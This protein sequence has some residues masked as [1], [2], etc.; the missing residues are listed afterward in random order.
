MPRRKTTPG[1]RA[2][3]SPQ[4]Q[5]STSLTEGKYES[6]G[7]KLKKKRGGYVRKPKPPIRYTHRKKVIP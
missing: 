4:K 5:V 7:A 6:G 3:K 1:A 2:G